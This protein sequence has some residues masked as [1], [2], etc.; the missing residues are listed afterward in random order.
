M[1]E[2]LP[3]RRD[4]G[5]E[6]LARLAGLAGRPPGERIAAARQDLHGRW[7]SGERVGAE[8]YLKALPDLAAD[9]EAV[10]DLVYGEVVVREELGE[11]PEEAEYAARFP[12]HADAVR[13][14]FAVHRLFADQETQADLSG[15]RATASPGTE[16]RTGRPAAGSTAGPRPRRRRWGLVAALAAVALAGG[17]LAVV[18]P[19]RGPVAPPAVPPRNEDAG[20]PIT[21][22]LVLTVQSSDGR[23]AGLRIGQDAGALPVAA[24]EEVH[25]HARLN[26]PAYV[27]LVRID[28][29]GTSTPLYPWTTGTADV[30]LSDPPPRLGPVAEIDSPADPG[31]GWPAGARSGLETVLLL[32]RRTP[33]PAEASLD[34]LIGRLPPARMR[35]PQEVDLF[36][37]ETPGPAGDVAFGQLLDRLRGQFEL[38]R[39]VRYANWGR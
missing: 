29:A 38:V 4:L 1:T 9:P 24:G 8:A 32:A 10:I 31:H 3:V 5:P 30:S 11:R 34:R 15:G 22:D 25:V 21:G 19:W 23:K 37:P 6:G 20:P 18:R 36:G 7:L 14:Q 27:Y 35:S 2:P 33:L 28:P 16:S 17:V 39:A 26:R 12:E 13:R